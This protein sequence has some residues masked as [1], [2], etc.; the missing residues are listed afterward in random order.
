MLNLFKFLELEIHVPS[1]CELLCFCAL[2]LVVVG[3]RAPEG[4]PPCGFVG[5][6]H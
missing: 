1:S 2:G 5:E 6:C 4:S 3:C